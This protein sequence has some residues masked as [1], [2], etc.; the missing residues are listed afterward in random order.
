MGAFDI[1]ILPCRVYNYINSILV[2]D[3]C[4]AELYRCTPFLLSAA[5]AERIFL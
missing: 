2:T 4:V 3:R 5:A 1:D